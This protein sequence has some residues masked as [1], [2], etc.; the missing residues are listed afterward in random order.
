MIVNDRLNLKTTYF[1][2]RNYQFVVQKIE[3]YPFLHVASA[4]RLSLYMKVEWRR[5]ICSLI[6]ISV[7]PILFHVHLSVTVRYMLVW[8]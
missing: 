1:R 2:W 8:I 4:A 5:I 7:F 6:L 3:N